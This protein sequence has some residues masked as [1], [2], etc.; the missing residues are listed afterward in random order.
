VRRRRLLATAGVAAAWALGAQGAVAQ[1]M[2]V[3][4][5]HRF[6]QPPTT[7]QC[8]TAIGIACYNPAQFQQAYNLNPLYHA[9]LDGAGKTI[10]IVDSFGSPTIAQDLATFDADN[11]L[12]APPSL[13]IIQPVG[14]VPAYN[15]NDSTMGGWAV[16]T[17]LDVEYSHA[18]AP[19][20][21]ILLVETP[22]AET[23][24]VTGFP[25]IVEAENYVINRHLG[26]VISQSFG[27]TEQ[28]FPSR[29][30]IYALRG[31]YFN[32]LVHRV[33][34]LG[35]SGD[36]G[37]TDQTSDGV[38]YYPFRVNSW[39][40]S[41]PLVT[42]VGGLQLHLDANGNQL[43][44]P[45]VWNDTALFGSPAAGGG[46]YSSVFDR[47]FYQDGVRPVVGD[48]RGTPDVSLSAAVDGAANVYMSFS[49]PPQGIT[50]PGYYLIGGTS[51][52][53]PEF[54]G[55]VAIADQ[56]AHHD[57][58]L[59]NPALY[60][61]AD[62][63]SFGDRSGSGLTD[64]TLG[65]NSVSGTN[66]GGQYDGPFSVTGFNATPGYDLSSGLGLPNGAALVAELAGG[67]DGHWHR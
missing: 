19:G 48:R 13:K 7:A 40:S 46:G 37:A 38:D 56:A 31:A 47:P 1:P 41:D 55:I 3:A 63:P 22:V 5:P 43:A 16:E 39:P 17:S 21:N 64:V 61:L 11:N 2:H 9:G 49:N 36:G 29:W 53:S 65:N 27:A 50:G 57:L 67:R 52:A 59:L 10:V 12:P 30:S 4:I 54:A 66:S 8:E 18:M 26:D 35:S 25:Q 62:R 42:S 44:P 15:P 24:G 33:T 34:V 45:N 6:A 28:T 58:G 14:Q 51:E 20:A 23:E 60:A 32:A